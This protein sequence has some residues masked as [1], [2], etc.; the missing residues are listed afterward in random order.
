MITDAKEYFHLLCLM[1]DQDCKTGYN[2]FLQVYQRLLSKYQTLIGLAN[3]GLFELD[4]DKQEHPD[5][6]GS[7]DPLM[8]V[9]NKK[10]S[11]V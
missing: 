8:D 7:R 1:Q 2:G 5:W 10:I 4:Y 9:V 6:I 3:M 11:R